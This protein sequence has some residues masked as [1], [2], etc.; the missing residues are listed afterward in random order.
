IEFLVEREYLPA[1]G[2]GSD[3]LV[4]MVTLDYRARGTPIPYIT[5]V[6]HVRGV[7]LM[8]IPKVKDQQRIFLYPAAAFFKHPVL[9]NRPYVFLGELAAETLLGFLQTHIL[10]K[11]AADF[12]QQHRLRAQHPVNS[13]RYEPAAGFVQSR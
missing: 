1:T 8:D 5:Q 12:R 3:D 13:L 6:F 2:L 11:R 9:Q 7:F 4:G 10:P